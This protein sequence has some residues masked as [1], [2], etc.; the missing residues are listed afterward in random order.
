MRSAVLILAV[1]LSVVASA[2]PL[3]V[4]VMSLNMW[5]G[6]MRGGQPL[7]Q[8]AAVIRAARADIVGVQEALSRDDIDRSAQLAEILGWYHLAQP[9]R[10]AILSRFPVVGAVGDLG[11]EFTLPEE[12]RLYVFN[13]HYYH[14]PYQPYQLLEIPFND[15][16]FITTEAEAIEEARLARG[17]ETDQLLHVLT[18]ILSEGAPVCVT[19]DFNEPSDLDWTARAAEK[20]L[21][22]IAVRWPATAALTEAGLVDV[23][24]SIHPDETK[25][26]GLTWTPKTNSDDP[27]DRHDRIDFVFAGGPLRAVS[28]EV[29]GESPEN[30]DIVVTPYP[31]DHR[32]VVCELV[33]E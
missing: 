3:S 10:T 9:D 6:G 7:E 8:M 16:R 18:P 17:A 33:V 13:V 2:E 4:R 28:A 32:G 22:P 14:T 31:S 12:K 26:R 25:V 23:F 27:K 11:A 1:L 24:R 29:V 21:A 30:A 15:G 20:G 5:G 19:G